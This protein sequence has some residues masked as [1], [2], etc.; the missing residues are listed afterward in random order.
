MTIL[1]RGDTSMREND[2]RASSLLQE[3]AER[4]GLRSQLRSLFL[5]RVGLRWFR[6]GVRPFFFRFFFFFFFF[7]KELD[8]KRVQ[9]QIRAIR[10]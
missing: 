1:E 6:S 2:G 5:I 3:R 10:T 8:R 9:I 4:G 7:P